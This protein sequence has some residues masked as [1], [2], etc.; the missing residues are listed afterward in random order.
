MKSQQT[1]QKQSILIM[2][3]TH[4]TFINKAKNLIASRLFYLITASPNRSFFF[5]SLKSNA[6]FGPHNQEVIDI[7]IGS[8]LG[9][10]W[11]KKKALLPGFISIYRHEIK[12]I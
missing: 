3:K 5:A 12:S 8:L 1:K 4:L 2:Q 11:E 9:D 10:C 6:R 7:I